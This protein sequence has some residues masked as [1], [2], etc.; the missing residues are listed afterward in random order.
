MGITIIFETEMKHI[1]AYCLLVLGGNK[2]PTADDVSK[3]LKDCGAT[4]DAD[5][6]KTFMAVSV[7]NLAP[8]SLL[9]VPRECKPEVVVVVP[10]LLEV[11]PHPPALLPKLKSPRRKSPRKKLTWVA[12]SA[13]VMMTTDHFHRKNECD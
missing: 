5:N 2:A 7:R 8:S 12:S 11:L 9:K 13:V 1:A 6:L 4:A 3:L 10:P